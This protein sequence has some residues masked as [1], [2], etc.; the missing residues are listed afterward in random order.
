MNEVLPGLLSGAVL[1]SLGHALP[2]YSDCFDSHSISRCRG[3]GSG[4]RG[5][6]PDHGWRYSL[7]GPIIIR[8][9]GIDAPEAGQSCRNKRGMDW[10]CGTEATNRL[11]ELVSER[12]VQCRALDRDA[13]GRIIGQ[14]FS[15]EVDLGA[16]LVSEGLAW[17]YIR[18]SDVY[19]GLETVAREAELGIWSGANETPWDYRENRWERA[20]A[21]SP[22]PGC[23][24]KG[25][26][27]QAGERIYHT[28]WSP[29]YGRTRIDE[30]KGE[31][32][33]CD[34]AEAVAA[35]WRAARWR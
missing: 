15:G 13:Y 25:N 2:N 4:H 6:G 19:A 12:A 26:I 5:G 10:G 23:P 18:Y 34:E 35:G 28:P 22:R 20:A 29:H 16:A 8:L 9:N 1:R 32:W 33:F 30:D 24:I 7:D 21:E 31:R 17:A 14:C 11:A 27:S 3:A